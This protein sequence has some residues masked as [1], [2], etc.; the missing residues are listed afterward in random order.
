MNLA[1]WVAK[2][3]LDAQQTRMATISNNLANANTT[4]YKRGRAVFED[5]LYQNVRQ[6]GGQSSQQTELPSGLSLGTGVRTVATEKLF[7][8]GGLVQTNNSLDVAIQGRGFLEVLMPDGTAAYTRDGSLAANDQGQ[9]VTSSGYQIQPAITL[10]TGTQ[11]VTIGTDGVVSV[12][13]A[14]Q[15]SPTQVG[16]LQLVDFINPSGLQP[17]GENLFLESGASGAPQTGT[18][19]L[20]GLGTLVQGSLEGSNVNVVEELVNMIETQRVYEMNSKAISTSDQMLQYITN[21]T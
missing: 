17:R 8:Q 16:S 5:L 6:V 15:A 14:G 20:N 13:I 1:L 18:P 4:G 10:P 3:G 21:N 2:T 11:S 12:Q 19:G 9:L 7:T